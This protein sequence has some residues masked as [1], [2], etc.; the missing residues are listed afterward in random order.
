MV[1]LYQPSK[2]VI[3]LSKGQE[4]FKDFVSKFLLKYEEVTKPDYFNSTRTKKRF[5]TVKERREL[6]TDCG[7][8]ITFSRG[9]LEVI[10]ET[11]YKL[12]LSEDCDFNQYDAP[13]LDFETIK[14]TLDVFDLRDDQAVAVSKGL[15]LKRGVIQMPTATGKSAIITSIIKRLLER[16]PEMKIL[17]LAPTLSTVKNINSTLVKNGLDSKVFGHPCKEI[18][19]EVTSSLVQSLVSLDEDSSQQLKKI[20]A[21]FYDECLPAN[22]KILL[23]DGTCKTILEIYSDE[24]IQEVMSY[25]VTANCY[26]VKKILR[27]FRTPFDERFCKVYYEDKNS[28]E[29]RG[30]TCTRN[31]KIY[32][33]NRGY[34]PA[35]ELTSDDWIK[36][37][38][39]FARNWKVLDKFTYMKVSRVSFNIGKV[40]PY[41]YNIE[42]EDNHNYFANDVLVSNCHHLSCDSWNKLNTLLPNVEYSL[43]FSALSIDKKEIYETDIRNISYNSSLIVGCSGR[44]LMHM[45][46]SYYIEKGI[47]ALPVVMRVDHSVALPDNFDE[48]VWAK[49]NKLGL[50]SSS[51]T[52]K[53]ARICSI[54]DKYKRKVLVLISEK[55]YAFRLAEFLVQ[56][57]VTDFGISFGAGTG[58]VFKGLAPPTDESEINIEY[59][60]EESLSVV[61]KLSSDE[62]NIL[63]AT[64]HLDEG[65]DINSLDVCVLACGGKKDRRVIQRVGRVLRKSKTGKYAYVIDFNDRGSRVLSRQSGQRLTQYKK[66][67]G[68]PKENIFDGIQVSEVESKFKELE[69]LN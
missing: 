15:Y 22:S 39:P 34:I 21:V 35:E 1:N 36:V 50:M 26:E 13:P 18:C 10:P 58:Y 24:S 55:D 62:I 40:A 48:S 6:Y 32:T 5:K 54:F 47:I 57:G 14:K 43:G 23:P 9:L 30:V 69:G 51:R 37:D 11:E 7:S 38:Y 61:D 29:L 12:F 67:I 60:K 4:G 8:H 49:L 46:P 63:I 19:S 66:D 2:N 53:V 17:V 33:K 59:D 27:K 44:V 20:D 52:D 28:G 3:T 68:V 41:K 45:D 25:N 65:V 64:S 16:Y 42:V 56:Y 31:H